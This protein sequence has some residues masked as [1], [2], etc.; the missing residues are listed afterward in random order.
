MWIFVDHLKQGKKERN[1]HK[2]I[3]FID[4]VKSPY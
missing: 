4:S 2:E 1:K 3:N